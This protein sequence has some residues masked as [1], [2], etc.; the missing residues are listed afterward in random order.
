MWRPQKDTGIHQNIQDLPLQII[1][2]LDFPDI[3][4]N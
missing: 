1:E 4:I 3:D 2:H